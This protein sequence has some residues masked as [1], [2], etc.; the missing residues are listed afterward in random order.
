MSAMSKPNAIRPSTMRSVNTIREWWD[1]GEL[2][3]FDSIK[4]AEELGYEPIKSS[5][6]RILMGAGEIESAL[7]AMSQTDSSRLP[8]SRPLVDS[9]RP[10]R[11]FAI[12]AAHCQ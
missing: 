3:L 12:G 1:K 5:P 2:A 6:Q 4:E 7:S 9:R 10:Q 8:R 11:R